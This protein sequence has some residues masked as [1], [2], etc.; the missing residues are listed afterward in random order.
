MIRRDDSKQKKS[1]EIRLSNA[2]R[3]AEANARREDEM[4]IPALAKE[5]S[6]WDV[7]NNEAKKI[8]FELVKDWTSSLNF[9][10]LF[11]SIPY[12]GKRCVLTL[13]V[14]LPSLPLF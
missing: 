2:Y 13:L 8:D 1:T 7:Y 11:V 14:R 4:R 5:Y 9:L 6:G 12:T 3:G 10:L